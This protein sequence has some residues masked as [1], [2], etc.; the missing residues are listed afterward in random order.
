[1]G[2]PCGHVIGG[3]KMQICTCGFI[4]VSATRSNSIARKAPS[5][6]QTIS[7]A[8]PAKNFHYRQI[9]IQCPEVRYHAE[10]KMAK[11]GQGKAHGFSQYATSLTSCASTSQAEG[12]VI[13]GQPCFSFTALR[14]RFLTSHNASL[15]S[16]SL[17][18][19]RQG[20]RSSNFPDVPII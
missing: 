12:I 8:D 16:I 11:K 14:W 2:D 10:P 1:M 7:P 13:H 20:T 3:S 5:R 19:T 4:S 18:P 17:V 15:C 9:I 6:N